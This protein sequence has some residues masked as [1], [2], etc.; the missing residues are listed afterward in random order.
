MIA[1]ELDAR[2]EFSEFRPL[3]P[4]DR[5]PG[6]KNQTIEGQPAARRIEQHASIANRRGAHH[7][8]PKKSKFLL[9]LQRSIELRGDGT[10]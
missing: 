10:P 4:V 6:G 5:K 3:A 8:A 1:P 9:W 2:F 7:T